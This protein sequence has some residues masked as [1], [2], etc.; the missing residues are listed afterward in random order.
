MKVYLS[1]AQDAL[2]Q[3]E[4]LKNFLKSKSFDVNVNE[5][6][7]LDSDAADKIRKSDS[8]VLVFSKASESDTKVSREVSFAYGCNK[9]T[10]AINIESDFKP[11]ELDIFI[12][13]TIQWNN[14]KDLEKLVRLINKTRVNEPHTSGNDI[15]VTGRGIRVVISYS[16]KN[17]ERAEKLEK[18]LK[19]NEIDAWRDQTGIP[20]GDWYYKKIR[21]EIRSRNGLVVIFSSDSDKSENVGKE[22]SIANKYKKKV[23]ALRIEDIEPDDLEY[24]LINCQW[25]D[26]FNDDNCE[27]SDG[28]LNKLLAAIKNFEKNKKDTQTDPSSAPG[29]ATTNVSPELTPQPKKKLTFS[30]KFARAALFVIVCAALTAVCFALT[31]Y[32]Y[33]KPL[34][35][36]AIN[37]NMGSALELWDFFSYSE[38]WDVWKLSEKGTSEEI[39]N[40]ISVGADFNIIS[41]DE[42]PLLEAVKSN[43][44]PEAVIEILNSLADSQDIISGK[45]RF[46]YNYN[47]Y[48]SLL[49]FAVIYGSYDLVEALI[50]EGFDVNNANEDGTTI[51]MLAAVNSEDPRVVKKI[52][53]L[54]DNINAQENSYYGSTALMFAVTMSTPEIVKTL[55]DVGADLNIK[56]KGGATALMLALD[57]NRISHEYLE[58]HKEAKERIEKIVTYLK[59]GGADKNIKDNRGRY[60]ADYAKWNKFFEKDFE[61]VKNL[62][63]TSIE[64]SDVFGLA[65]YGTCQQLQESINAGFSFNVSTDKGYTPLHDAAANNIYEESIEFLIDQ[66]L[67]VNSLG[68]NDIGKG[69]AWWKP[70]SPIMFAA[71]SN[72]N[73]EVVKLLLAHGAD[74]TLRVGAYYGVDEALSLAVQRNTLNIAKIIFD[75]QPAERKKDILSGKISYGHAGGLRSGNFEYYVTLLGLAV[76]AGSKEK[77][78]FLLEAGADVNAQSIDGRTALMSAAEYSSPEMLK[79]LLDAG[80]NP[81]IQDTAFGK[82]ALIESIKGSMTFSDPESLYEEIKLLIE[83]GADPNIQEQNGNTMLLELSRELGNILEMQRAM[84]SLPIASIDKEPQI[85]KMLIDAGADVNVHCDIDLETP[86]L[87]VTKKLTYLGDVLNLEESGDEQI[88]NNRRKVYR[89]E[90][91]DGAEEIINVLLE[92]GADV[93]VRDNNRRFPDYFISEKEPIYKKI[94]H[95]EEV[96]DYAEEANSLENDAFNAYERGD[97]ELTV[98]NLNKALELRQRI[99]DKTGKLQARRNVAKVYDYLGMAFSGNRNNAEAKKYYGEALKIY[100]SLLMKNTSFI[101]RDI[102]KICEKLGDLA[103]EEK[104]LKEANKFYERSLEIR[105]TLGD[106]TGTIQHLEEFI[107]I[108]AQLANIAMVGG[109]FEKAKKIYNEL[110]FSADKN[111][112]LQYYLSLAYENLGVIA[113]KE[114]DFEKAREFC[115]KTLEINKKHREI[116]KSYTGSIKLFGE[117]RDDYHA[118]HNLAVSNIRL[119]ESADISPKK[120]KEYIEEALKIFKALKESPWGLEHNYDSGIKS[121][122]KKLKE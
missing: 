115:I 23:F 37:K 28:A 47:H 55:R 32:I 51:L 6:G 108:Y 87:L 71:Y 21:D 54:C 58:N 97:F 72:T 89:E 76:E 15:K 56:D 19:D 68:A 121:I 60:A 49:G 116:L 100:E 88:M 61:F 26:W 17:K 78:K 106:K 93:N 12:D 31:A 16:S 48:T 59:N 104:N 85:F 114:G 83:A 99:A 84:F 77:V 5:T 103:L 120:R 102:I 33:Y 111:P 91:I 50:N 3:A 44:Y 107:S 11:D 38:G 66:G 53:Q 1:Y 95:D 109:D 4:E 62:I 27:S 64:S 9:Y 7:M 52:A 39:S 14:N 36:V 112:M 41:G 86:L 94:Q 113:Y 2:K 35:N 20:N 122:E 40:A 81:N 69:P 73:S 65:R 46:T 24:F 101:R 8:F 42:T 70:W 43:P 63:P 75:A 67:D 29:N 18:F 118:N 13:N 82:T 110:L 98:A 30:S 57:T 92:A 45:K 105:R 10:F 25:T 90:L 80:A 79:L 117:A 34:V 96:A 74:V 119:S 22:L